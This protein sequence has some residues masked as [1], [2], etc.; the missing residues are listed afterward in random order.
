MS[1]QVIENQE[2]KTERETHTSFID[3]NARD[4]I[5]YHFKCIEIGRKYVNYNTIL[6]TVHAL[7]KPIALI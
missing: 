6:F 5:S 1:T 3:L 4:N 7:L 2:R